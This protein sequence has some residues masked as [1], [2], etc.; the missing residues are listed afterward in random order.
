MGRFCIT[1]SLIL[2]SLYCVGQV[3]CKDNF[4]KVNQDSA[5]KKEYIT[6]GSKT[7]AE[8]YV[9]KKELDKYKSIIPEIQDSLQSI[10]K[11]NQNVRIAVDSIHKYHE[12]SIDS[13]TV[14]RNSWKEI[15]YEYSEQVIEL[16]YD[17]AQEKKKKGKYFGLGVITVLILNLFMSSI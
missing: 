5:C 2:L 3:P 12:L 13:L 10:S 16:E 14:D 9:S 8:F 17:L 1:I 15:S 4:I 7:F 11:H 6:M